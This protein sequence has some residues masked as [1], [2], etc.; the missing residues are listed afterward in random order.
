M[1]ATAPLPYGSRLRRFQDHR[2]SLTGIMALAKDHAAVTEGRTI[3]PSRVG[4]PEQQARVLKSGGHNR[5]IGNRVQKGRWAGM[6]IYTLT[7]EERA[8]CPRSCRHWLDCFG[9]KMNWSVRLMHGPAL[10]HF[11]GREL[12]VLGRAHPKGFVVRLHVLGDF[13]SAD[14]VRRW[15]GWLRQIPQLHVF[16]YTAWPPESEIGAVVHATAAQ[17]WERFAIR[18]SNGA[19]AERSTLTLYEQPAGPTV[20][21]HD[22]IVCPAQTDATDCC[23]TCGLCW[24][25]TRNIAFLAH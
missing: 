13:Y 25:T 18:H 4:L 11:L 5:K 16:G 20:G 3:F 12:E 22:A 1:S 23:A 2:P 7:L 6:P 19:A 17:Q 14:Y 9:N 24:G 8:T 15:L 10:E 21:P